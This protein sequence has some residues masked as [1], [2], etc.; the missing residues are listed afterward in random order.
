M[1]HRDAMSSR[2]TR[3]R[4]LRDARVKA[5][6]GADRRGAVLAVVVLMTLAM[7]GLAH[8]LLVSAETAY[9]TTRVRA[10]MVELDARAA[11]VVE[12]ELARRW[13]PWTDSV[14]VGAD[15]TRS[16]V[17]PDSAEIEVAWR[18]LDPEAW[19]LQAAVGHGRRP[20]VRRRRLAWIYDPA[21][22]VAA[23]PG[24]VSVGA[25]ASVDVR[26]AIVASPTPALGVIARPSLGR[27][28]LSWLLSRADT[29]GPSGTPQPLERFGGCDTGDPWS[30]GDPLRPHRP[31]GA[32]FPVKGRAGS[33]T[34]EGGAGQAVLVVDGDVTLADGAV[35][36]GIVVAAG[37]VRVTTGSRLE[38]RVIAFGGVVVEVGGSIVGSAAR[39]EEALSGMARRRLGVALLL[40]PASR[41]DSY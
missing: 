21:T 30:W 26:G 14:A 33:L 27:M 3:A 1:T 38:G 28:D 25:G 9:L 10:G 18:R 17:A 6:L 8:G 7:L 22:R 41:L 20:Q 5:R 23:L 29:V 37:I 11:G 16:W 31:C 35:F 32:H 4:D 40:H 12:G 34:L 13:R 24:V 36:Q 2:A 15:R 19:L 39:A